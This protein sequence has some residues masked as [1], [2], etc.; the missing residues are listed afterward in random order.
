MDLMLYQ[1]TDP[2]LCEGLLELHKKGVK[3]TLLV[4]SCIDSAS[5]TSAAEECYKNLTSAG[6]GDIYKTPSYYTFSCVI[7]CFTSLTHLTSSDRH[8]KFWIIDGQRVSWSTGNWS[9]TDY[10][11]GTVFPPFGHSGWH[12]TNRDFTAS[13]GNADMVSVFQ[14]VLNEDKSR[15]TTWASDPVLKCTWQ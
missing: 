10:P 5:D 12:D 1:V 4:S 6:F 14:N 11:A 2:G 15:G 13:I 3:V 8:Q 9:P 7:S